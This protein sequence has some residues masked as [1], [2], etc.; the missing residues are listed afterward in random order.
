MGL[1]WIL[2]LFRPRARKV[3]IY[4]KCD[5]VTKYMCFSPIQGSFHRSMLKIAFNPLTTELQ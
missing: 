3:C 2:I 5:N 4:S 1:K